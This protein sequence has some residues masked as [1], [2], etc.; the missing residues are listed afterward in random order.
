VR[1]L[2][3]LIACSFL[4]LAPLGLDAQVM[5]T[6]RPAIPPALNYDS[7]SFARRFVS[8]FH[9]GEV[10]SLWAHTADAVRPTMQ[11]KEKWAEMTATFAT[12]AGADT[13]LVE[14][15]WVLQRGRRV[16][17]RIFR[18]TNYSDGPLLLRLYLDADEKVIGLGLIP[19]AQ[20]EPRGAV[21]S[22]SN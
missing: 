6:A 7:V 9:A 5:P 16:Y 8:W 2:R 4:A 18:G 17:W 13:A 1:N 21:D 11:G 3:S 14:E 20:A 10:D 19:L 12:R 15:R 22:T